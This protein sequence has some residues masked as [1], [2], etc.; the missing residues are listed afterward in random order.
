MKKLLLFLLFQFSVFYAWADKY[1]DPETKVN[2][3][4][5]PGS[6]VAEVY[7]T[8]QEMQDISGDITL[9]M[10]FVVDDKEYKVTSIG[11][12]AF[13]SCKGLE[14]ITIPMNIESIGSYAF[15]LCDNL[16]RLY[17]GRSVKDIDDF[18]FS[19]SENITTIE[20]DANNPYYDS[21]NNCN[22]I[23]E[24]NKK[25]LLLGCMNTTIPEEVE[26]IGNGAF[27]YGTG[28]KDLHI[29]KNVIQIQESSFCTV[30][31]L[32]TITVDA[33]NPNYDS[34]NQCNAIIETATNRLIRG[35]NKTVIPADV[36]EICSRAFMKCAKL[37]S[38]SIPNGV[39]II[40]SSTFMDCISLKNIE[41]PAS[42]E[43]I[44]RFNPFR[45]CSSL[46]TI[47]IA[48]GNKNYV[49]HGNCNAIIEKETGLLISGC[50]GT[51]T[52]PSLVK[53]IHDYAFENINQLRSVR[54]PASVEK[55]GNSSF[56]GCNGLTTVTSY[57][58]KPVSI[59]SQCF[60]VKVREPNTYGWTSATLRVPKGCVDIYKATG[61]WRNFKN[62]VEIT[63][64][65]GDANGDDSVNAADV[66]EVMNHIMGNSSP[67][68]NEEAADV[69]CDGVVDVADIG[70][71]VNI[72]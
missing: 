9:L 59:G 32:E 65:K 66:F 63:V 39:T 20:V 29:S 41:I 11:Y 46:Q 38:I 5:T 55:F 27:Y 19:Q 24:T 52:I 4:Y 54:I 37:E 47:K 33:T 3:I 69:N 70:A 67:Y 13:M 49:T 28:P 58:K 30:G 23:I 12:M 62:I 6:G 26:I 68:F 17:I 53:E 34:R 10:K 2:Y 36:K 71:I 64:E 48:D 31:G 14:G 45:G 1:Q 40:G 7:N 56:V 15:T 8:D 43:E 57:S 60:R 72:Y 42:V 18:A 21:R 61:G 22:A 51:V 50:I 25:R 44:G 16:K 35:C